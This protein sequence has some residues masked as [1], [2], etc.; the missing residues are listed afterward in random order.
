MG[1]ACHFPTMELFRDCFPPGV[2]NIVSGSGR[3]TMPPIMRSGLLDGFAFIGTS[4]AAADLIKAHPSPHRLRS[5]LGL[6]V[7]M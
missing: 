3:E 2:V 4:S 1:V 5:V 6:Q 7:G